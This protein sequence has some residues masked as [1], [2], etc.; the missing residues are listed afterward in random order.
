MSKQDLQNRDVTAADQSND[1]ARTDIAEVRTRLDELERLIAEFRVLL[2]KEEARLGI[3]PQ[4]QPERDAEQVVAETTLVDV[5][6][7]EHDDKF[8]GLTP[9]ENQLPELFAELDRQLKAGLHRTAA[10]AVYADGKELLSYLSTT[11]G[12]GAAPDPPPLFRAFSSGKA[13][14]A[15]TIWRLIDAGIVDVDDPVA[16]Y[17]PEFAQSGKSGI[18]IRHVLTHTA[19]LPNDFGRADVDWGDLGRISDILASMPAQYEPGKVIHYHPITFG[20]LVAEIV[21]RTTHLNFIETF[22]RQV[23]IPL[24]LA[25][26]HFSIAEHDHVTRARVL[27][28]SV[29]SDFHDLEMPSKMDWLLDNQILSPGTTCVTTASDLAKLYSA[30]S[31]RGLIG[32]NNRWLS[33]HTAANVYSPHAEAYDMETMLKMKIGQGVWLFDAQPNATASD[34]GSKTFAHGGMGTSIAWGDPDHNVAAAIL[35][36]KMQQE[37]KHALRLNRISAAIRKDLGLP[38]GEVASLSEL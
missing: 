17:W 37:D 4:T 10:V 13:M 12:S 15:S 3:E 21:G 20:I 27:P 19:G 30:V 28:L 22:E 11:S 35:T 26:T 33:E 2:E 7:P 23:K 24:N 18:T 5:V 29:A 9:P 1:E 31:N 8:A 36:D 6:A 14:A 38:L 25:N 34:A 16:Q 32:D